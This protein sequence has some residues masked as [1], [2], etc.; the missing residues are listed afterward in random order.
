MLESEI[1]NV[2][3]Y[4]KEGVLMLYFDVEQV[5]PYALGEPIVEVPYDESIFLIDI[6]N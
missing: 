1:K 6:G 3:F 2:K 5:G 4:L